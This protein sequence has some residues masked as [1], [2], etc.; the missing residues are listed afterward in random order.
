MW[1]PFLQ[2]LVPPILYLSASLNFHTPLIWQCNAIS[3]CHN[4]SS[5]CLQTSVLHHLPSV[6]GLTIKP[7]PGLLL[8][9]S[10]PEHSSS[11]TAFQVYSSAWMS[12]PFL[13]NLTCG[14]TAQF[15]VQFFTLGPSGLLQPSL[16]FPSTLGPQGLLQPRPSRTALA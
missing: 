4:C 15:Q 13:K 8:G 3:T 1:T 10:C 6:P 11:C 16:S 14:P 2:F 12:I 5:L 9:I 7:L